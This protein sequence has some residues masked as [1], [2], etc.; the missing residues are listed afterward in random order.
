MSQNSVS[1]GSFSSTYLLKSNEIVIVM[2]QVDVDEV[3]YIADRDRGKQSWMEKQLLENSYYSV[4]EQLWQKQI[5]HYKPK[6][7]P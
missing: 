6:P 4:Q 7:K 5:V 3:E 1:L 2:K